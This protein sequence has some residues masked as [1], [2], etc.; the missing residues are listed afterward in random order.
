MSD[1]ERSRTSFSEL[2][3]PDEVAIDADHWLHL[4][5]IGS[6]S[7]DI[8]HLPRPIDDIEVAPDDDLTD[9][10]HAARDEYMDMCAAAYGAIWH[11][12]EMFVATTSIDENAELDESAIFDTHL[13]FDEL[14]QNA[15]R[16][17]G[18]PQR[19]SVNIVNASNAFSFIP[20]QPRDGTAVQLRSPR[21]ATATGNRILLGVQDASPDWQEPARTTEDE[22]P[23][24]LRGLDIVRGISKAVWY[25]S[26]ENTSK[27]VWTLI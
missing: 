15:F 24:H 26:N 2:G 16:Y 10:Q 12:T 25:Q 27:W 19:I 1:Y 5:T 22:L 7:I 23:E 8:R 6:H 14:I 4:S 11:E 17:G 3:P 18:R 13:A 21:S 9:E 20:R